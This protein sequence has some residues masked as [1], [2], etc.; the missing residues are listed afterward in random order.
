[1]K[2]K[3]TDMIKYQLTFDFYKINKLKSNPII[4]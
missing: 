3:M 2:Q 4:P 1:M